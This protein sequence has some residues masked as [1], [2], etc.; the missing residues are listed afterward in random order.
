M[1]NKKNGIKSHKYISN[2]DIR[3]DISSHC[4]VVVLAVLLINIFISNSRHTTAGTSNTR[5]ATAYLNAEY[6]NIAYLPLALAH[7]KN[8]KAGLI[9]K[10]ADSFGIV[11]YYRLNLMA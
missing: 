8:I 11:G 1:T 9:H 7:H 3:L 2:N 10:F 5:V 6:A 4:S